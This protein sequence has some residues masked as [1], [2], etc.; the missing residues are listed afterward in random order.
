MAHVENWHHWAISALLVPDLT[1]ISLHGYGT[2]TGCPMLPVNLEG[3]SCKSNLRSVISADF[4]LDPTSL[5]SDGI[6]SVRNSPVQLRLEN[7][8]ENAI[9]RVCSWS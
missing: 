4:G 7:A 8:M 9:K 2:K 6:A 5:R 1:L 3:Q